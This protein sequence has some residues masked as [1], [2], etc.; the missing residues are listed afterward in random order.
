[1][2][3][4]AVAASYFT[5]GG[6]SGG[7]SQYA[8]EVLVD[9]P[10]AF[11]AFDETSGTTMLDS[12]GNGR[13]G[14][15]VNSPTLGQYNILT[16]DDGYSVNFEA[17]SNQKATVPYAS[18]M[19]TSAMTVMTTCIVQPNALRI[20]AS[21]YTD[22]G[23]D[24]S[25]F[26]YTNSNKFMLYYRSSGGTNYQID[27]GV[28]VTSGK[29]YFVA[30]YVSAAGSGLR[31]YDENGIVAAATGPGATLNSSS[32]NLVLADCDPPND[33]YMIGYLDGLAYFGTALTTGRIDQLAGYA[34]SN[35]TKWL[36]RSTG[37]SARNG[38]TN[39]T[40][41][42]TPANAG[43][44]LVAVV[45][46]PGTS[47]AS[48]PGWTKRVGAYYD[49]ELAV[50]TRIANAG[51]A[52][53][54]LAVSASNVPLHYAVYEFPAGSTWHSSATSTYSGLYPQ[55]SGLPGVST[56]IFG[57]VSARRILI[58]PSTPS[59]NWQYFWKTDMVQE[60]VHDGVTMGVFTGIGF[61]PAYRQTSVQP[62]QYNEYIEADVP[63]AQRVVFALNIP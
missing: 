27:S 28:T 11:Y 2:S 53:L 14:S 6:G 9:G 36:N 45:S 52:G 46:T 50:F 57:A 55:L 12:S 30:A 40:A 15:Y 10:L 34:L 31:V 5:S 47:T 62:T 49:T 43:S 4:G 42:F 24:W 25:W 1:M 13:D 60:T 48:T 33:Y 16:D 23:N 44:L 17:A 59:V 18:W 8:N 29:K 26:L 51:D 21:R 41:S 22:V 32:R 38:T 56:M 58:E 19:N 39:H 20:I 35:A 37:V 61:M 3:F 63:S 7:S 54:T